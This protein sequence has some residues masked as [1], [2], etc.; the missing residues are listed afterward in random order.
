MSSPKLP[1]SLLALL[2]TSCGGPDLAEAPKQ[3]PPPGEQRNVDSKQADAPRVQAQDTIADGSYDVQQGT[4]DDGEGEYNLMLLGAPKPNFRTT[5]L[6]MAR[7]T[8]EEEKAG[9]KSYLKVENQKPVLYLTEDFKFEYIHNV[10]EER[11]NPQTGQKETVVVRQESNFWGPFAGSVA[12]SIAG[13]AI[14]SML[15]RPQ[16]YVPPMYQPGVPMSGYG[17]YGGNYRDAVRGYEDR[18]RQSPAVERNRTVF[19]SNGASRNANN[20]S[21]R[22]PQDLTNRDR[23]T[24]AGVGSSD[25]KSGNKSTTRDETPRGER[26]G[27]FG[28]G[29]SRSSGGGFGSRRRR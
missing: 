23:S 10:T 11:T 16:Y 3:L 29:R 2:T 27:S 5:E 25:L 19:R 14:G 8:E 6:Q 12:G 22:K 24:G 17:G 7:L 20:D 1:L 15:F 28:S 13:Q 4:F 26:S 9:K 21:L 18:Y